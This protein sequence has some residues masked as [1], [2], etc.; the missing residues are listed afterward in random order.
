MQ[1]DIR[2]HLLVGE[3]THGFPI[4]GFPE[5]GIHEEEVG[6]WEEYLVQHTTVAKSVFASWNRFFEAEFS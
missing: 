6:W 1:R 5:Q 3:V 2:W 4:D